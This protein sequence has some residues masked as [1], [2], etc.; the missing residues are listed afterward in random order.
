VLVLGV[1]HAGG[2]LDP[3][4]RE[5]GEPEREVFGVPVVHAVGAE[6]A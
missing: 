1:V 6:A 5:F 2:K 4:P 3:E